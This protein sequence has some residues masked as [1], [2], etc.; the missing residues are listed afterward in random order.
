MHGPVVPLLEV[1]HLDVEELICL[2]ARAVGIL[3]LGHM[4]VNHSNHSHSL[5]LISVSSAREISHLVHLN[6]CINV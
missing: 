5:L 3:T 1:V 6:E 2:L 4:Q